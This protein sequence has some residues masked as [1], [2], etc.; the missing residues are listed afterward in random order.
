VK[1]PGTDVTAVHDDQYVSITPLML[2]LTDA[3]LLDTVRGWAIDG[4]TQ[5][6]T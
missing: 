1:A 3:A 2:D 4:F 6:K 5:L